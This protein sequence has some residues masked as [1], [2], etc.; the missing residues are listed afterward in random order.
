MK[1]KVLVTLMAAVLCLSLAACGSKK[2]EAAPEETQ[3]EVTDPETDATVVT[4]EQAPEEVVQDDAAIDVEEN[5]KLP[6]DEEMAVDPEAVTF[7]SFAASIQDAVANKNI[8]AL[9][10]LCAY[11]VYVG[12]PDTKNEGSTIETVDDFMALGVDNVITPEMMKAIAAVDPAT[13]KES[14]AGYTMMN[15]TEGP[16]ITFKQVDGVFGINGINY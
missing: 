13:L 3:T 5:S 2:E 9:A 6:I 8:E 10:N 16:S 1:K 14:E 12:S 15:G 11:P 4:P 7:E